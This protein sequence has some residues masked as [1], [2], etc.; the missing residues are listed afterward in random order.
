MLSSCG[1]LLGVGVAFAL[2]CPKFPID[3]LITFTE[4]YAV[5]GSR[6]LDE[7]EFQ[8]RRGHL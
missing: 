2:V 5:V 6:V 8:G 1:C 4:L 3:R 7:T